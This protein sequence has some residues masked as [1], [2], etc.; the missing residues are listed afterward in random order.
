MDSKKADRCIPEQSYRS[1]FGKDKD[2]TEDF[3][4]PQQRDKQ[5]TLGSTMIIL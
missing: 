5:K 3:V 4:T 1:L 2:E